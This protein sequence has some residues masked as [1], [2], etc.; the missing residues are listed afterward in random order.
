MAYYIFS[1]DS[2][3]IEG[4]IYK[5]A[6]NQSDLNN[7]PIL[8]QLYKVIEDTQTDFD[9]IKI[10]LKFPIKYNGNTITF[11]N[12]DPAPMFKNENLLK[13]YI[14]D[15]QLRINTFLEFN[16]NHPSFKIWKNYYDQ[17]NSFKG[18]LNTLTYP[19]NKSLEQYFKE[20]SQPY[21]STLQIP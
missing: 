6:E 18:T 13:N 1:K 4:T 17:L 16:P 7:L 9:S 15:V 2:D 21:F 12:I 8:S 10:G 20:N 11:M 5:I 14:S 19:F 3:N